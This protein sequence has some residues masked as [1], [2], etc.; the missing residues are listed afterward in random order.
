MNVNMEDE[1]EKRQLA[2]IPR[3]M[4]IR[5]MR[6][7]M[8]HLPSLDQNVFGYAHLISGALAGSIGLWSNSMFRTAL[9]VTPL[10]IISNLSCIIIP[11]FTTSIF[12]LGIIT[13]PLI[14]GD[15]KCSICTGMRGAITGSL[16]GGA[17]PVMLAAVTT[18]MLAH[19]YQSAPVPSPRNALPFWLKISRPVVGRL[20]PL[21]SLQVLYNF[22]SS[23]WQ[24]S[25]YLKL[26]ELGSS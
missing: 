21:L 23:S 16:I 24:H 6:N 9:N 22:T 17:Y 19:R 3:S 10:P 26:H 13:E 4:Y 20:W 11:F 1:E 15:L 8:A 14:A 5:I 12:Y 18:S 25:I 7:N 2:V